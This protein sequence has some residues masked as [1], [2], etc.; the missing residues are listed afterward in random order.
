MKNCLRGPAI[1]GKTVLVTVFSVKGNL[2][3]AA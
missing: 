2:D 3:S 1:I